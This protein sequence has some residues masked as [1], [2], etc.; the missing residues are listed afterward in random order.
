MDE[1]RVTGHAQEA[2]N[3]RLS[4]AIDLRITEEGDVVES[5]LSAQLAGAPDDGGVRSW[6]QW[7]GD[8]GLRVLKGDDVRSDEEMAAAAV[9]AVIPEA[10]I[11]KL[12]QGARRVTD[13]RVVLPDASAA[14]VEATMHTD[15]GRRGVANARGRQPV[16]GLAHHWHVLVGDNRYLNDYSGGNA[17]PVKEVRRALAEV[18][19][20]VENEG[21]GLADNARIEARCE[22]EI[23]RRWR[24][25]TNELRES[26][27]PLKISVL[28]R[29]AAGTGGG[30]LRITPATSA[31]HFSRVTDVSALVSAVQRSIDH[32]LE[33]NQWE[34]T[35]DSKWLVVVLD[36]GE[37][38]TQLRGVS[39]FEDAL[40]DF[41]DL[42]FSSID[43]VWVVA[44]EGGRLTVLRCL[45]G[46]SR[47]CLYRDLDI[48]PQLKAD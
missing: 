7:A 23:G 27:P 36:E 14:E 24:W 9:R 5:S 42:T 13:F 19:T 1:D 37:A 43:E 28:G 8:K 33:R 45:E 39:E 26:E 12:P 2:D 18:L 48:E 15:G 29:E 35:A 17:F 30:S 46:G 22:E 40:L 34:G 6:N 20:Q 32:K 47:W 3:V 16:S 21:L 44:F 31:F 25:A 4:F 41:S 38:A 11:E 10:G